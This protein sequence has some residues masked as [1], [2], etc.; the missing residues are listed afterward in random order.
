MTAELRI[1]T[2]NLDHARGVAARGRRLAVLAAA[3][4]DIWVLTETNDDHALEGYV[5]VHS[6]PRRESRPGG[7]WVS[8]WSRL[9]VLRTVAVADADRTAAAL[10]ETALGPVAVFGAVLPWHS[11]RGETPSDPPPRNWQEQNRVTP[12]QG[13]AWRALRAAFPQARLCVAGDLNM[14]LGGPHLY[15]TAH[16]RGLLA[17]A[18][19]GAGLACLTAFDRVPAGLLRQGLID[20]VLFD[21]ADAEG[22]RVVAA[23]EGRAADGAVLS[24]HSGVVVGIGGRAR[25]SDA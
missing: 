6:A 19:A 9:P 24:D 2:W 7:R 23:W 5:G 21:A 17:Q 18:M 4:A 12:L 20:H 14:N 25:G 15:G 8:I 3:D 16:G 13:E 22:A 11:D 1:G 10:I